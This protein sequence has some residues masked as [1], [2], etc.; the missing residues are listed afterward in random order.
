MTEQTKEHRKRKPVRRETKWFWFFISPWIIG[1]CLFTAVP[2]ATSFYYS[3]TNWNLF[4]AGKFIGFG[5]YAKLLK[6][7]TFWKAM[8]N[9]FYYALFYVILSM[10]LSLF[11]AVLLNGPMGGRR[12]F[13]TIFYIP[14]LVPVVVS[15]LLFFRV[16]SPDGP[17]NSFLKIFGIKGPSWFFSEVWSKPALIVM[18]LWGLGNAF[19]LLLS[20][21]QGIPQELYE[22]ARI[23]GSGMWAEF[24]NITLPMLSPVIFYNVVMGV[25]SSL[26]VFTQTFVIGTNKLMPGGD[27][28][29][30]GG[31]GNSLLSVVQYLY[32]KGFRD[33][34]MGY[35]SAIAW[36][37]LLVTLLLTAL[38]FK[39]SALWTFYEE[40]RK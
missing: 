13:R 21:L 33:F 5:N 8:Y 40:E 32:I 29:S 35:A 12:V 28:G 2:M 4:Q 24:R 16:L 3:F 30:G 17:V 36:V 34:N 37:L 23:D 14:T 27:T 18:S 1:F 6:D 7:A 19:I 11:V 9:T 25:I 15:S 31:P 38:I 22:A 39:S 10:A 20:G 26:Q